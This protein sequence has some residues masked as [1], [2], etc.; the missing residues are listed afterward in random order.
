LSKPGRSRSASNAI[1]TQTNSPGGVVRVHA[2]IGRP[3]KGKTLL[4]AQ[5]MR[6]EAMLIVDQQGLEALSMRALAERLNVTAMS[7]YRYC[8]SREALLDALL[9]DILLAHPPRPVTDDQSWREVITEFGRALHRAI[10]AHPKAAMLFAMRPLL[11]RRS[12][13][14]TDAVLGCLV[15]AGFDLSIALYLIHAVSTFTIG[16]GLSASRRSIEA[17]ERS[18]RDRSSTIPPAVADKGLRFCRQLAAAD[19]AKDIDAEFVVGLLAILD[20]FANRYAKRTR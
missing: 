15:D 17:A 10:L 1:V 2:R 8:D 11:A 9:D 3:P 14:Y 7:L 16:H 20:G 19:R 6:K 5:R 18:G 4:S 12:A 13:P